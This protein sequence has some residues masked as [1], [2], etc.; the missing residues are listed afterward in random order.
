MHVITQLP[1]WWHRYEKS[2]FN[3][4]LFKH[5]GF[6]KKAPCWGVGGQLKDAYVTPT[7]LYTMECLKRQIKVPGGCNYIIGNCQM[8]QN[9]YL[10]NK[11]KHSPL[12]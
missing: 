10:L 11:G 6:N 4:H 5:L 1:L 7:G 8:L 12:K 9:V 2:P 3:R